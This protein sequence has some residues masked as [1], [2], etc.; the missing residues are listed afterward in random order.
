[1]TG[2]RAAAA[3]TEAHASY[4]T[5]ASHASPTEREFFYRKRDVRD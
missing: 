2:H 5:H 1:M 4:Q 3:E